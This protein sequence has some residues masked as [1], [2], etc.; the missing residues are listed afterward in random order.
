MTDL[1]AILGVA[2]TASKAA[3]KKAYRTLAKV[4]HP[5]KPDGDAVKFDELTKAYDILADDV[6]RARYDQDGSTEEPAD[7]ITPRAINM[8]I[9]VFGAIMNEPDILNRDPMPFLRDALNGMKADAI[10]AG[11]DARARVDHLVK[12]RARFSMTAGAGPDVIGGFIHQNIEMMEA[13]KAA[14]DEQLIV[15]DKAIAMLNAYTYKPEKKPNDPNVGVAPM[16]P[17]K[18]NSFFDDVLAEAL[19]SG[20]FNPG[21]IGKPNT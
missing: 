4:L 17:K 2:K 1:Y 3:I 11:A 6:K 14:M 16:A 20:F 21:D 9:S 7:T 10:K 8:L 12:V 18:P 15:S 19:K 5:D 13:K